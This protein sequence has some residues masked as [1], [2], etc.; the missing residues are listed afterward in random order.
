M[1]TLLLFLALQEPLPVSHE[2][3]ANLPAQPIGSNDLLAITVYGAPELTRTVRVSD[4]G[5]IRLPMLKQKI[6][7]RGLMPADLEQRITTALVAEA[8]LVDPAVTVNVAEYHSRPISVVGAVHRPL[9]FQAWGKTTLLEAIARAEGLNG[10]AGTEILVTRPPDS[11]RI[12]AVKSLIDAADPAA[13]ITLEGGEEVRVPQAGR[14]FVVG[15]VKKPGTFR[16]E[17]SNGLTVLKALAMAEGLMPFAAR[18]AYLYR[19][20]AASG[21]EVPVDLRKILD[22]KSPDVALSANDILYIPDNR[23]GRMTATVL[24]KTL[25]FAASTAS[26]ILILSRP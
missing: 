22:R 12:I 1:L 18:E 10:D 14:V 2:T 9:T 7:A 24:E 26:G 13:N 16:I 4:D 19:R 21:E 6:A 11:T 20:G 15:N 23:K 25:G 3:G 8:I 17:D 5:L